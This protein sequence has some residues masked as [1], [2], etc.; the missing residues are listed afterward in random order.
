MWNDTGVSSGIGKKVSQLTSKR[1]EEGES[2]LP[3]SGKRAKV[4]AASSVG[5]DAAVRSSTCLLDFQR[6]KEETMWKAN[7]KDRA[8]PSRSSLAPSKD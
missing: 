4:R 8:Q 7:H 6:Y 1:E 3:P 2:N 5:A